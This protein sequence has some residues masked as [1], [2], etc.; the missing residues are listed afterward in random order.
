MVE[1]VDTLGLGPSVARREG[2][3]P[4]IP[5]IAKHDLF[6]RAQTKAIVTVWALVFFSRLCSFHLPY[7]QGKWVEKYNLDGI[8]LLWNDQMFSDEKVEMKR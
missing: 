7:P 3:S 5:T 8:I 1:L 6:N 2:S 4:F